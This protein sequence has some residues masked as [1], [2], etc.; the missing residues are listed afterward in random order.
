MGEIDRI[1][2]DLWAME[3]E[4][5]VRGSISVGFGYDQVIITSHP[6]LHRSGWLNIVDRCGYATLPNKQ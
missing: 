5:T 3:L 1:K 6:P 4:R 2:A